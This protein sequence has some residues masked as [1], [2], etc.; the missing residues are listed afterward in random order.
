M[1]RTVGAELGITAHGECQLEL[2]IAV[3]R[4]AGQQVTEKHRK[5]AVTG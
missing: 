4:T 1:D 3:A 5:S 2:Q